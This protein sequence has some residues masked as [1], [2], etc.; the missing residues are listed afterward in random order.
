VRFED[1]SLT[2]RV[3]PNDLDSLGHVNNATVLEYLEAGRWAWMEKHGLRRG[4]RVIAVTIRVE[5]DYRKEIAPQEVVVRTRLE[6]P[7]A[8]ELE[9]AESVHYRVGFRQQIFVDSER[10]L[11]VEAR[12]Q[13]GFVSA[14]DRSLCS[15]QEYLE[16]ARTPSL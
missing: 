12:I 13:A 14:A 7:S 10:Q 2:L 16:V 8:E 11:A 9:D 3:R 1:C 4:T 15:L 5:V 6:S